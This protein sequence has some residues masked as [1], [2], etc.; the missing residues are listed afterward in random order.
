MHVCSVCARSRKLSRD[1]FRLLADYLKLSADPFRLLANS[2]K[3]SGGT[4]PKI[5]G[6]RV[7]SENFVDFFQILGNSR[8]DFLTGLKFS[9]TLGKTFCQVRDSRKFSGRLFDR[10]RLKKVE[11]RG[12]E[13]YV[14]ARV[15]MYVCVCVCV[16]VCLLA[17][18]H[19]YI[20]A[21]TRECKHTCIYACV[22][23]ARPT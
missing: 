3:L 21:C 4:P 16:F 22:C 20:R 18:T 14:R 7:C 1:A 8:G 5:I 11:L 10:L 9:E 15:C 17:R 2:R 19:F 12:R 6:L 23:R 13:L